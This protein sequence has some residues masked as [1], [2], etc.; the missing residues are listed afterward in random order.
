MGSKAPSAPPPPNFAPVAQADAQAATQQFQLGQQQLDWAKNQFNQVWPFAQ[1]YLSAQT[2]IASAE[3]GAAPTYMAAQT[4]AAQ[5]QTQAAEQAQQTY[6][7]TYLPI[8]Q[9]FASTALNYNT[10]ARA[11]EN[12]ARAEADVANTFNAQRQTALSQLEGYGIDPSQTRFQ[13]LDLSTRV[14]QA[15]AMA[16]SGT[17]SRLNT[18]AT[19]LALQGE[20]INTGRGY[21]SSV[22]SA[23]ST[24][25]DAA[26]G[27]LKS[28][29]DAGSSGVMGATGAL[30]AAGKLMGSP[31]D[32]FSGGTAALGNWGN[33]LAMGYNNQLAAANFNRQNSSN[34][35]SGIGN[36]IGGGIGAA[37]TLL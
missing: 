21:P 29:T 3:A 13:A 26:S 24:A 27:G 28:G 11:T 18:E 8:E 23:Y 20:A 16:A 19:G 25:T 14:Q 9:K 15:A 35:M 10:P 36:L 32:Y 12:A 6:Q 37:M 17:Q 7:N 34:F 33:A 4:A 31:T 30:T 5:N 22:A 2:G 1:N